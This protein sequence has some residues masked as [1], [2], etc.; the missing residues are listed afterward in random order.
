MEVYS[1][2]ESRE[3]TE[4]MYSF[5]KRGIFKPEHSFVLPLNMRVITILLQLLK[6]IPCYIIPTE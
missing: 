4:N 3:I 1:V 6:A 2:E 5:D